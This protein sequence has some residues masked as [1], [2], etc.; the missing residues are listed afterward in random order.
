MP[1]PEFSVSRFVID[2][3]G[4]FI[5]RLR[6]PN[7]FAVSLANAKKLC[8]RFAGG[9]LNALIID[10]SACDL[11][12]QPHEYRQLAEVFAR[13][14]PAGLPFAY[15]FRDDQVAHILVMTRS[16]ASAG[17]RVQAFPSSSAAE[18]WV[19]RQLDF[20]PAEAGPVR[21]L[22]PAPPEAGPER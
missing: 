22:D 2:P 13:G 9:G 6:G 8:E 15:V 16:L 11:G 10:Y 17:L 20:D 19:F 18:T 7:R 1:R 3:P 21:A 5:A 14:L 12:H 4:V